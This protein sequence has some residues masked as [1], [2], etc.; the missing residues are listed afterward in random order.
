MDNR[1][2]RRG[3]AFSHSFLVHRASR[4]VSRD[5]DLWTPLPRTD[6]CAQ[7]EGA[8]ACLRRPTRDPGADSTW[9]R[10]RMTPLHADVR[11]RTR[12]G[13]A[14]AC[15]PRRGP[16]RSSCDRNRSTS[17]R[18][19]IHDVQEAPPRPL[20][21]A[22]SACCLPLRRTVARSALDCLPPGLQTL[23]RTVRPAWEGAKVGYAQQRPKVPAELSPLQQK[24]QWCACQRTRVR[25]SARCPWGRDSATEEK[26]FV[27][28]RHFNKIRCAERKRF[29]IGRLWTNFRC[30]EGKR[31]LDDHCSDDSQ[32]V[33]RQ[34][35]RSP[36]VTDLRVTLVG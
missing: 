13:G 34:V 4:R 23:Q 14:G 15:P 27:S 29:L 6:A 20:P 31:L 7:T 36:G 32:C 1:Q 12:P 5:P 8:G 33:S 17:T 30:A 10:M 9:A 2:H 28:C 18:K 26:R 11:G 24:V 19:C 25:A 35:R 21:Q 16:G 22:G 3:A